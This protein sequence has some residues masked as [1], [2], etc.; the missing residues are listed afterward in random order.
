VPTRIG[1]AGQNR[2]KKTART[3]QPELNCQNRTA[4]TVHSTARTGLT[5]QYCQDIVAKTGLT[6]QGWPEHYMQNRTNRTVLIGLLGQE[7]RNRTFGTGKGDRTARK[8]QLRPPEPDCRAILTSGAGLS[9]LCGKGRKKRACGLLFLLPSVL[10]LSSWL[11]F[12]CASVLFWLRT[13]EREK[14]RR[15]PLLT[16]NKALQHKSENAPQP[17]DNCTFRGTGGRI[18]NW[19]GKYQPITF[20]G[21]I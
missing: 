7:S 4:R 17:R 3:D 16:C 14:N 6:A 1:Q 8:G 21:K 12:H 20:S 2:Q 15:P 9:V 19:K 5:G 11:F 10:L 13:C 18:W